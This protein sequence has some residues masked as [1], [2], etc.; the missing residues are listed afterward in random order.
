MYRILLLGIF[1]IL[2]GCG[3]LDKQSILVNAG[4]TKEQ[5]LNIMGPP[6]DRQFQ[7]KNEAWQF[8][9]TG[10]G[11]GYHDYRIFW[12]FDGKVTGVNTYKSTRPGVSC[13][14]D[15]K[16]INWEDAPDVTLEIRKR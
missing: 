9:K 15:I 16:P 5:V 6:D 12:F 14:T 7:G 1:I 10:A 3:S 13:V 2:S 4:D 11:F 8:C